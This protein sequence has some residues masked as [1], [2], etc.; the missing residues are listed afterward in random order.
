MFFLQTCQT[1]HALRQDDDINVKNNEESK[2]HAEKISTT[3]TYV[4]R[5][6]KEVSIPT[7]HLW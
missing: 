7:A 3:V 1:V 2:E 4:L 6:E 5:G